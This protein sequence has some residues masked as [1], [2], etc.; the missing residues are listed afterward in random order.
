MCKNPFLAAA[1]LIVTFTATGCPSF[2]D[3]HERREAARKR[4]A[5]TPPPSTD[6]ELLERAMRNFQQRLRQFGIVEKNLTRTGD[7]WQI[8]QDVRPFRFYLR[9]KRGNW[10]SEQAEERGPDYRGLGFEAD[11]GTHSQELLDSLPNVTRQEYLPGR[12]RSNPYFDAY[13]SKTR[14]VRELGTVVVRMKCP[15]EDSI[16]RCRLIHESLLACLD[17]L[18]LIE[19]TPTWPNELSESLRGRLIAPDPEIREAAFHELIPDVYSV[20][21]TNP[22]MKPNPPTWLLGRT[23]AEMLRMLGPPSEV[24]R[25][26][27]DGDEWVQFVYEFPTVPDNAAP[28]PGSAPARGWRY[29]PTVSFKNRMVCPAGEFMRR[30]DS[31]KYA[32]TPPHLRLKPDRRFP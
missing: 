20:S 31:D 14:L 32:I 15:V 21:G 23:T 26:E 12:I 11:F 19:A 2:W 29:C 9:D 4:A 1:L 13:L 16:E 25:L 6:G 28:S 7:V 3:T 30:W 22:G 18:S 5:S 17:G 24:G 27:Y 10:T 8:E